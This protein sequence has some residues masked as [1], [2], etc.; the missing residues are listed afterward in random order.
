WVLGN[1][2]RPRVASRIGQEQ[3]RVAAMLLLTMR[4]TPT[5]YYGE[6][7]GMREGAIPQDHLRDPIGDSI[8]GLTHGRGSGR[9]PMQWDRSVFAG[10][11]TVV[12]W[13]PIAD[14]STG[15]NVADQRQDPGSIYNLYRR[16]LTTRRDSPALYEGA[17]RPVVDEG[18]LLVFA[19]I[20][21]S[22][23]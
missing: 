4:G 12:P 16:L 10:F 11:S 13:L 20:A 22:E 3:A 17:Y 8:V 6:E 2:D 18:H 14:D 1:H 21:E 19:R 7:I 9:P 23:R 5:I 15:A